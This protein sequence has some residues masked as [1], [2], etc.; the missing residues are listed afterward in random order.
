MTDDS[1]AER[2]A[3]HSV[4]PEI[5]LL[6]CAFHF[7]QRRWT[8]LH[9]GENRIANQHRQILINKVKQLV[10]ADTQQQLKQRYTEFQSCEVV[11]QYPRFLAHMQGLWERRK[12]WAI[13][14]RKHLLTRGNQTNNYAEAGIRILKELVFSRV[15]VYNLVQMFSFVTECLELY[16]IRSLLSVAHNRIDR[17]VSLKY[18]GLR[19]V[20]IA[21]EHISSL[22]ESNV[23]FLVNS[24]SEC[25]VKYLVD[26]QL[27]TCSCIAG[28]DGSPCSH[29]AAVVKTLPH[30]QCQLYSQSCTR[31]TTTISSNSNGIQS[32]TGSTILF[33]SSSEGRRNE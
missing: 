7:L 29:Q 8:W 28:K 25:G 16:Y 5:C 3:I 13:C 20:S 15:K 6:L 2:N 24:M 19:C 17:Y 1:S 33:M 22:D 27:G 11:K 21:H 23:T 30:T 9:D 12:E 31:G 4:W 32:Y 10:Y 14:Y 26:M 18:Q